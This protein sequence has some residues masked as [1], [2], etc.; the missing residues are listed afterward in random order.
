M[1][2]DDLYEKIIE[3]VAVKFHEQFISTG[4]RNDKETFKIAETYVRFIV[5][6]FSSSFWDE[7][8]ITDE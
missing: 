3:E 1:N 6:E 2:I 4:H 7:R 5:D 8:V